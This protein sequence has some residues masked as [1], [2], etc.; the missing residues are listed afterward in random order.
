MRIFPHLRLSSGGVLIVGLAMGTA[1]PTWAQNTGSVAGTVTDAASGQPVG[2]VRVHVARTTL[3]GV[4][5]LH[6]LYRISNVPAGAVTLEVRRIGYKAVEK[7]LTLS[8]GQ[9]AT[10]DFSLSASV[11][12]LEEVVVSGT[13]GDQK[14]RAQGAQVSEISVSDVIQTAPVR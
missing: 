11:V 13:A 10:Q 6:G 1:G 7:S 4:T 3:Q 14:R 12:T 5:D 8:A 9:Q 2:D